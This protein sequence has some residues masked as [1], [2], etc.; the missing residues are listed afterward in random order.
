MGEKS[1]RREGRESA[2]GAARIRDCVPTADERHPLVILLLLPLSLL[3]PPRLTLV[4]LVKALAKLFCMVD[5]AGHTARLMTGSGTN[6]LAITRLL[7]GPE[8]VKVS[9]DRQSTPN[10]A[11]TSPD[12]ASATSSIS[13]ECIRTM[14][15]SFTLSPEVTL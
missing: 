9:I 6:M 4:N 13:S 12:R 11:A 5:L 1:W 15:L 2:V 7:L 8:S 14:R 3:H 10:M